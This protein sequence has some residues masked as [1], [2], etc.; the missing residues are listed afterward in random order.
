MTQVKEGIV[1]ES[2]LQAARKMSTLGV[3][4]GA[5]LV[6]AVA[7]LAL[8][9]P[10]QALAA[11]ADTLADQPATVV[12]SSHEATSLTGELV[13][14]PQVIGSFS[15]SQGVVTPTS[16]IAT[17]LGKGVDTVLCSGGEAS[18][19]SAESPAAD[20]ADWQITVDGDG[21]DSAFTATVGELAKDGT[22]TQVLG[23]TC[24]GNP[25]DGR[26]T[27]NAQCTG[28]SIASILDLAGLQEEA[29]AITFVS[30]DGYEVSLPLSYVRQRASM[31]VYQVNG[32][33]LEN[34]MGG[35]N[36]LWLGSTSARYFTRDVVEIR[37]S[38]EDEANI[39]PIPGTP[40]AG[41]SRTN[42]PNVGVLNGQSL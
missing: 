23:C 28:I 15:F 22:Q 41:D 3:I 2:A 20:A 30:S 42:L 36:Q 19:T 21:V 17:S 16:D 25:A 11:G 38:C 29:N 31:I 37:V 34:S 1:R 40:E 9:Q 24:A 10:A 32:E 26:A 18:A 4:G 5:G 12:V 39:P 27:A 13:E 8:A 33:P 6:G 35:T 7:G 14:S